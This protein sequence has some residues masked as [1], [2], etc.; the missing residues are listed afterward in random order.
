MMQAVLQAISQPLFA[1]RARRFGLSLLGIGLLAGC[2]SDGPV[3]PPGEPG[4]LQATREG[5]E[6]ASPG[7]CWGRT[8]T[9]AIVETITDQVQVS[10]VQLNP[11]GSVA[12]PPVYQSEIRH[13]MVQARKDNWFETP[14][15]E[16][17]TEEF[18]SSLQRALAARGAYLGAITGQMDDAT[19]AALRAFQRDPGPD[20]GVLSLKTARGLGLIAVP[21]SSL[22]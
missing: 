1:A 5:P 16:Q 9:P 3:A 13:E 14:C 19:R 12:K 10:P 15:P 20:S 22:G 2:A 17:L 6:G 11:D 21:R 4:V 7:S 18:V 8:V